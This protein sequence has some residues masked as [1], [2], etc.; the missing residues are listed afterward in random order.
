MEKQKR[1]QFYLIIAV[2]V[3]TLYNILPTVFYYARPLKESIDAPRAEGVAVAMIDRVNDLEEDAEAWLKSF[4]RLLGVKPQAIQMN[5]KNP[6]TIEVTFHS[7][8]DAN[9]FKR[10][11][12][13]AGLMIPF[14]PS[15]LELAPQQAEKQ[16]SA[17]V[18]VSRNISVH[19]TP[20]ET[21]QLFQF[22]PKYDEQGNI[23]KLYKT[24]VD[25][26]VS[27]L[28]LAIGGPSKPA[29][30][31][32]AVVNGD[33][34]PRYD[35]VIISLAKE[36]VDKE[37][38][39]GRTN[40]ITKRFYASFTQVESKEADG[41][42]QKFIA[43]MDGLSKR[44]AE[45]KEVL[46]KEQAKLKEQ[47]QLLD[48]SKQQQLA[49]FDNQQKALQSALTIV[50]KD[51]EDFNKGSRPLTETAIQTLFAQSGKTLTPQQQEQVINLEG[52]NP[53]FK[54]LT[55]DWQ[56]SKVKFTLY[57]DVQAA[58]TNEGKM[59]KD[60]FIKDKVS[61]SLFNEIARIAYI[62][63]ETITP[64]SDEYGVELNQLIN[65][66]SFLTF[67]LGYLA[68]K[69]SEQVLDQLTTS[70]NPQHTDLK[71]DVFPVLS[72]EAY[73]KLKTEDQKLGLV[74]YA[75]AT[76]S[77]TPPKGFRTGSIYIIARG[78]ENIVQKYREAPEA[79]ESK[80]LI[81]DFNELNQTLQQMGF[82]GYAAA[83]FDMAPEYSK[84]FIFELNDYYTI[85][86][87]G[88]REN[89]A[90]KGSKR[91]A[92][93]DF[94]DLEQR[95]LTL[96]K[97]D[98]RIQEDLVKWGEAYQTA[99]VDMDLKNRYLVPAP[100]KNVFWENFKLSSVK[101][102]RGDERKILKWG[103]DLSGGKTVRIG[104]LDRNNRPVTNPEDLKQAVNELYTRVNKMGVSERTYPDREL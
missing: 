32:V 85:L 10:F 23:A 4:S 7:A 25:D 51:S 84:D 68:K 101:Y 71:R 16:D 30:Q 72:R 66:Q 39:L 79:A 58:I 54:S 19:I 47:G 82:I 69:R 9:L 5:P 62:S 6:S 46:N 11:L 59:E 13:K 40:P 24:I 44:I 74:V 67:N 80:K 57:P 28:A 76:E 26:R 89:F 35:D 18:L 21:N 20:E 37:Q 15:Q 43:K 42:V 96:N 45:Q 104:L 22:T 98:D 92:V 60:A 70:W 77:Q 64:A 75:P 103:L 61:Q 2:L 97:I 94:T 33:N 31:M 36:I 99:Q 56:A 91:Y 48:S 8:E 87:E 55:I 52:Y 3:L 65:S 53:F 34:D 1:W 41:L 78:M 38:V 88:T 49:V 93:L 27:Q 102:F 81:E 50:R 100:T 63:D 12:P 95:I 83:N 90:V 14:I 29:L 86:L 17:T 73:K